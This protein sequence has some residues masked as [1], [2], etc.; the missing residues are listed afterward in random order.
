MAA[1]LKLAVV[2]ATSVRLSGWELME[3]G[4]HTVSTATEL[5]TELTLLLTTTQNWLPESAS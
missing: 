3:G 2:P 5:V 1:T 4:N